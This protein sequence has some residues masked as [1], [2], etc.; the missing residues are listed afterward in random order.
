MK[1]GWRWEYFIL[2]RK[3]KL[4]SLEDLGDIQVEEV[5]VKDGLNAAGHY[6]DDVVES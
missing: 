3:L 5:A 2:C 6:G 1:N 4:L